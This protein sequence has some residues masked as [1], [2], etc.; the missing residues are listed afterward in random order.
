MKPI[1][2]QPQDSDENWTV[3]QLT[4]NVNKFKDPKA[5][6]NLNPVAMSNVWLVIQS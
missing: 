4:S 2:S 3:C 5:E 1:A 6:S